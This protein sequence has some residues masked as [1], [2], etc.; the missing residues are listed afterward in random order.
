MP[1]LQRHVG[2]WNA[3]VRNRAS[4]GFTLP[5]ALYTSVTPCGQVGFHNKKAVNLKRAAE[6]VV[7]NFDGDI[8]DTVKGLCTIP[9]VGPKMSFLAMQAAY[10]C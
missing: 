5:A 9:G 2:V 1:A 7:H 10:G 3:V 6:I 4:P 8:P